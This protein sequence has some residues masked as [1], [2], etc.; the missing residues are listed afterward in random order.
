MVLLIF[1]FLSA[2]YVQQRIAFI[3]NSSPVRTGFISDSCSDKRQ[4]CS[5]K[6]LTKRTIFLQ[7]SL[8]KEVMELLTLEIFK[9]VQNKMLRRVLKRSIL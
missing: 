8:L 3:L 4:G 9:T 2:A 7:V 1:L 5:H 6:G